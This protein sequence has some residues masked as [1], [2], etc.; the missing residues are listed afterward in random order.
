MN[1][2]HQSAPKIPG[3]TIQKRG[4]YT[5]HYWMPSPKQRAAGLRHKRLDAEETKA[6]AEAE[7][8]NATLAAE[9]QLKT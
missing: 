4:A 8:I 7:A 9:D 2:D 3:F 5:Y 1:A 6:R